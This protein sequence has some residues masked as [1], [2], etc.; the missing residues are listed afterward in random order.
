MILNEN[1]D[2]K[3]YQLDLETGKII[4]E[5]PADGINKLSDISYENKLD[6]FSHN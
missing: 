4:Q 2:T 3:I 5:L 6:E 1:D